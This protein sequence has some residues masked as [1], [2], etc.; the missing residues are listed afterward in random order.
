MNAPAIPLPPNYEALWERMLEL[1]PLDPG[2]SRFGG[3]TARR[4]LGNLNDACLRHA[5]S[6]VTR[7]HEVLRLAFVDL[8]YDP[9]IAIVSDVTPIVKVVDLSTRA[10]TDQQT[11]VGELVY[12]ERRRMFDMHT[13]PLWLVHVVHLS[14][15]E[16]LVVL[17]F[18]HILLDGW[19]GKV[20]FEEVIQAYRSRLGY[21]DPLPDVELDFHRT[22]RLQKASLVKSKEQVASWA[23]ELWLPEVHLPLPAKQGSPGADILDDAVHAFRFADGTVPGLED[24]AWRK[25]TTAYVM[26]MAAYH[27]LLSLRTGLPRTIVS[28]TTLGRHVPGTGRLLGQFTR[29]VFIPAAIRHSS[30]LIDVVGSIH[31]SMVTAVN[32]ATSFKSLASELYPSFDRDRPWSD[33]HLFDSYIQPVAPALDDMAFDGLRMQYVDLDWQRLPGRPPI[34]TESDIPSGRLPVWMKHSAPFVLIN[35]DR[36]GGGF[37]YNRTFF[38]THMVCGLAADFVSIVDS[39]ARDPDLPVSRLRLENA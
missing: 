38:D 31:A 4:I 32:N 1:S 26:L 18:C 7:R 28:T 35:E 10:K 14:E 39:L 20:F 11:Y 6:D 21:G 16:H 15:S 37:V 5:L 13:A 24:I 23:K 27:V 25:R 29:D 17:S 19:A 22:T 34:L 3:L 9:L 8:E 36:S 12:R 30:P 2:Q 33:L